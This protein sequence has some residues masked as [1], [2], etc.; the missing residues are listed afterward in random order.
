MSLV[1]TILGP[2]SSSQ[3]L[4]DAGSYLRILSAA[5]ELQLVLL[6]KIN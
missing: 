2:G 3:K 6:L 4:T 1:I 5:L